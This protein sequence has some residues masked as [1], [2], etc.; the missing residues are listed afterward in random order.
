MQSGN[1][2]GIEGEGGGKEWKTNLVRERLRRVA[3]MGDAGVEGEEGG[4]S[5]A[6]PLVLLLAHH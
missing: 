1:G 5:C 3:E 4:R 6:S 2:E